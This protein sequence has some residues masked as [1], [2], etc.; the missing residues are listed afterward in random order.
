M[1]KIIS[2][3]KED[4][5]RLY[6]Q[7]DDPWGYTKENADKIRLARLSQM[8]VGIDP[9]RTLDIG[10]GNGFVT[11][12][13]PGEEVVGVEISDK[14]VE[15]AKKRSQKSGI[16]NINYVQGDLLH[17]HPLQL[18]IFDLICIT[19]VLYEQYIGRS[20]Y[21]VRGIIDKILRPGGHLVSCHIEEW[22]HT[23]FCYKRIDADNYQY[24]EF[25]HQLELYQK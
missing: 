16:T 7:S 8:L 6:E 2:Q 25:W 11:E 3:D 19:G 15:V 1:T 23:K 13:L 10:S 18:G 17:I 4:L 21:L 22:R 5:D 20:D 14:A 24:S 9:K 12:K